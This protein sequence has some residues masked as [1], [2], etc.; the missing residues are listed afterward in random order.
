MIK[1]FKSDE[2]DFTNDGIEILDD[3][4]IESYTEWVDNGKW[5]FESKFKIDHDKSDKILNECILQLPTEKGLQPFRIK[6]IDKENK[7]YIIVT[8][9]HEGF[10]FNNN[11]ILDTY[12]EEKSGRAAIAQIQANTVITSRFTLSSDIDIQS[13]SRMVRKNGMDALIGDDENSF[14]NRWGGHLVLNNHNIAMNSEIGEDRD[15]LIAAGKNIT[16]FKGTINTEEV[17]TGI[18]AESYDG[19]LLP[20]NIYYSPLA[21]NYPEKHIQKIKFDDIK[22]KY[23][24][25]SDGEEGYETLDEVYKAL[26]EACDDLFNVSNIDKPKC[27]IRVN[28]VELTKT[29]QYKGDEINERIYQGDTVTIDL[30]DYGFNVKLKNISNRYNS[31]K[32]RYEDITFG[33]SIITGLSL[34]KDIQSKVDKVTELV[35]ANSWQELLD[36]SMEEATKLINEG[37][38]DSYVAVKKN[39]ILIMDDPDVNSAINVIRMNKNGIAYSMTGYNGPYTLAL[40]IDGVINASLIRSGELDA[41]FMKVGTL[42]S[43]DA[44]CWWNLDNGTININ[45]NLTLLKKPDGTKEFKITLSDGTDLEEKLGTIVTTSEITATSD[46]IKMSVGETGA[47]N[48]VKNSRAEQNANF[49]HGTVGRY[50]NSSS[51]KLTNGT[52]FRVDN[53]TTSEKFMYSDIFAVKP[54]TTYTLTLTVMRS[55]YCTGIDLHFLGF[56][57]KSKVDTNTSSYDYVHT[58]VANKVYAEGVW[59]KEV[60][61]FKTKSDEQCGY[62]RL[63]NNGS[64]QAGTASYAYFTDILMY[65]GVIKD[66]KG[67]IIAKPWCPYPSELYGS[68]VIVDKKGLEVKN[69][70]GDRVFRADTSEGVSLT[71]DLLQYDLDTGNYSLE[72][73]NNMINFYDRWDTLGDHKNSIGHQGSIQVKGEEFGYNIGNTENTRVGMGIIASYGDFIGFQYKTASGANKTA[74][75]MENSNAKNITQGN[76]FGFLEDVAFLNG[77]YPKWYGTLHNFIGDIHFDANSRMNIWGAGGINFICNTAKILEATNTGVTVYGTFTDSSD[78]AFK[79]NVKPLEL[80]TLQILKDINIYEYEENGTV[81]IG[82]LAQEAIE[83]IPDII[84]GEVTDTTIEEANTMTDEE[85]EEKLK[86]GG[87]S[88][89]VYSMLSILWDANKKLLN[90]IDILENEVKILKER[91]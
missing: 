7:K 25:H 85:R 8:G 1:L 40:T 31:L 62:I 52:Y 3:I 48:M 33:E 43:L 10:E 55:A 26:R 84:K 39:E 60:I 16:Y 9:H 2:T 91:G 32:D 77:A 19:I 35:G 81:E 80:D 76:R 54:N 12:I 73:S 83:V 13:S 21:D 23:S 30:Q 86:N 46:E 38:K 14:I 28:I 58:V 74:F 4:C 29:D 27:T 69:N 11:F 79:S 36:Q 34:I 45:N 88:V 56:K 47:Y 67:D 44:S 41:A 65:E 82:L 17:V 20:E 57:D 68:S 87:A 59:V 63:D 42:Q 53:D 37:I 66:S 51:A 5:I 90:K 22:Y 75:V 72:I 78:L 89:D 50:G 61:T 15:V 24:E 18:C 70:N 64:S 6:N 49:W 71:G